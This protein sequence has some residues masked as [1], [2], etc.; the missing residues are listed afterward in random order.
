MSVGDDAADELRRDGWGRAHASVRRRHRCCGRERRIQRDV[1]RLDSMAFVWAV[2]VAVTIAAPVWGALDVCWL[3]AASAGGFYALA[4]TAWTESSADAVNAGFRWLVYLTGIALALL[5]ARRGRLDLWLGGLVFGATAV[6]GY[7][8]TTRLFPDRFGAFNADAG[9]RCSCRSDTGTRS[10]SSRRSGR[11]LRPGRGAGAYP[12]V[13]ALADR[14]AVILGRRTSP[15]AA[16]AGSRSRPARGVR[17]ARRAAGAAR[18]RARRRRVLAGR[19]LRC[20]PRRASRSP[21]RASR[22]RRRARGRRLAL[23]L[24]ATMAAAAATTVVY[25]FSSARARRAR[26]PHRLRRAAPRPARRRGRGRDRPLRLAGDDRAQGI[27]QPRRQAPP[28]RTAI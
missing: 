19:S 22:R 18:D 1:L 13:R 25:G 23:F 26:R 20:T 21:T 3:I 27:P 7:A 11:C 16:A 15:T 9:Y 24:A 12:A 2:V 5:V 17:R 14:L 8:V 28:G 6:C 10:R 4:S